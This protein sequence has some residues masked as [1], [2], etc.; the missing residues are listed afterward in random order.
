MSTRCIT[1]FHVSV[2]KSINGFMTN[3]KVPVPCGKCPPCKKRRTSGWSFRLVKEGERS[4]T[5]YFVTLT[6]NTDCVPITSKGYMSLKKK[7]LQDYF[8]RLRKISSNKL[9]YYA[10]GEYGTQK[11]R[12]HYHLI[13]FNAL[14]E[15]IVSAWSLNG[16]IL[17]NVHIGTV[18][19]ASIGYTLKYMCKESKVPMHKNDDRQPEWSIM[20]KGLGSNYLTQ[21]MVKWHKSDLTNRMYVPLKDGKKASLPRYYREKMYTEDEKQ[22]VYEHIKEVAESDLEKL[23]EKHGENLSF[24]L[25]ELHKN[26]FRK[27]HK[28]AILGRN[29]F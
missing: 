26:Q 9:K 13:L 25:L 20:S 4:L 16:V 12:P 15:N 28:E 18:N 17:G 24:H 19:E 7:D 2:T 5:G 8:K 6:Y 14:P 22:K 10:V 1:P 11:M 23:Y 29:T 27:M 3:E 21:Q